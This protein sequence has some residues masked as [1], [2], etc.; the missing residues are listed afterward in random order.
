MR[1]PKALEPGN[2]IALTC[3]ASPP[4]EG[5]IERAKAHLETMGFHVVVGASCLYSGGYL[6]G[7]PQLRAEELQHF[8]EDPTIDGI[9]AAKGG[10]GSVQIIDA[11]DYEAIKKHPKVFLGYSDI[12]TLHLALN[13]YADLETYHGPMPTTEWIRPD[14]DERSRQ[15]LLQTIFAP[16]KPID[17]AVATCRVPRS[18]SARGVL[19][20]G[21]LALLAAAVGTPYA[22]ET[23]GRILLI[24]DVDESPYRIDRMLWQLRLAGLFD[25]IAGLI[26]GPFTRCED[27]G[28]IT[29]DDVLDDLIRT[30]DCPVVM[31]FPAGH[32]LPAL[33][34][35][36]GRT[37]NLEAK[38]RMV[39]LFED[40]VCDPGA[41][42]GIT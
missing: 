30:L 13:R 19:T 9:I 11:L 16:P 29:V 25:G 21:N 27:G 42:R 23:N 1:I 6:A 5:T 31:D 33:T 7:T 39:R 4:A 40:Q 12:T 35:P 24:E 36:M 20:G 34:L 41:D 32:E 14:F 22:P 28:E 10:Y 15:S 17:I 37:L 18:G 2:R 8:F 26:L 3:P 38:E